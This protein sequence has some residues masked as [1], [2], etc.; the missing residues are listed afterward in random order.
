[1]FSL[2]ALIPA[3]TQVY[4]ICLNEIRSEDWTKKEDGTPLLLGAVPAHL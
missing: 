3:R 1:M 4:G 2:N